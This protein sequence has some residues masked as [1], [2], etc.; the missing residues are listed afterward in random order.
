MRWIAGLLLA[1]AGVVTAQ[2]PVPAGSMDAPSASATKDSAIVTWRSGLEVSVN[3]SAWGR[4]LSVVLTKAQCPPSASS[5]CAVGSAVAV[6]VRFPPVEQA[7]D[8]SKV[9]AQLGEAPVAAGSR[10]EVR[11]VRSL[12]SP[13]CADGFETSSAYGNARMAIKVGAPGPPL[14][15]TCRWTAVVGIPQSASHLAVVWSD[16][17]VVQLTSKP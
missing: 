4:T 15:I 5:P 3:G 11:L 2:R 16:T 12:S 7:A 14:P 1:G 10:Y 17:V 9:H 8:L 6:D 13:L